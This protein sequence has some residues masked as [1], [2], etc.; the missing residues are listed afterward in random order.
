MAAI[1]SYDT[2]KQAVTHYT[3]FDDSSDMFETFLRLAEDRFNRD[4]RVP[5]MVENDVVTLGAQSTFFGIDKEDFD[6]SLP[7]QD[8]IEFIDVSNATSGALR[9]IPMERLIRLASYWA[10]TAFEPEMYALQGS[11]MYFAPK[12]A[13]KSVNLVYYRKVTPIT[14]ASDASNHN[15]IARYGGLYLYAIL[16]EAAAFMNDPEKE[17]SYLKMYERTRDVFN[18][19]AARRELN[20]SFDPAERRDASLPPASQLPGQ[21]EVRALNESGAL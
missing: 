3:V 1:T 14:S 21:K 7:T 13:S 11:N 12:A 17:M 6:G 2:L 15:M 5:E 20:P 8:V 19:G 18:A 4:L 9:L 16:L 10:A